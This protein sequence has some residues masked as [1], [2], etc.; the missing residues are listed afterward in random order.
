MNYNDDEILSIEQ[1]ENMAKAYAS[2][3]KQKGF[4]IVAVDK[5]QNEE[6]INFTLD[7]FAKIK[8]TLFR[9]GGFL[10]TGKLYSMTDRQIKKMQIIFDKESQSQPQLPFS[11]KTQSFLNYISLESELIK[12]LITLKEQSNFESEINRII[13]D[14]LTLLSQVMKR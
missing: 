4:M 5:N 2:A 14:R 1:Y 8:L 11:D 3:L 12:N 13:T 6:L 9:L 10:N 7:I